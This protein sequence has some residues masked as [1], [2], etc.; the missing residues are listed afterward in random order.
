[1]NYAFSMEEESTDLRN[2]GLSVFVHGLIFVLATFFGGPLELPAPEIIE[3]DYMDSTTV[4][5]PSPP[6]P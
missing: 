1:M 2:Y 3:I 5:A 6:L 4:A